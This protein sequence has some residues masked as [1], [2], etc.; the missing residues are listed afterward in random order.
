MYGQVLAQQPGIRPPYYK[1]KES[2]RDAAGHV[3]SFIL[4][5]I[6]FEPLLTTV[7][8]RKI[9]FVLTEHF[10][11]IGTDSLFNKQLEGFTALE[12]AKAGGWWQQT[13]EERGLDR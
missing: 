11:K 9:A 6:G 7:Q 3:H 12:Q 2:Y 8:M 13:K 5:N 1:L 4:L 10:E